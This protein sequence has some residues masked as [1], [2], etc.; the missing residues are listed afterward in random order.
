MHLNILAFICVSSRRNHGRP[1]LDIRPWVYA[2]N[3]K[4]SRCSEPLRIRESDAARKAGLF[5]ADPDHLLWNF[6]RIR[7]AKLN[8]QFV[9]IPLH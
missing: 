2:L 3:S 7:T 1:C 6:Y 4:A 5:L 9:I 8:H